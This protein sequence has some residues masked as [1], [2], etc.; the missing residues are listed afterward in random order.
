[1]KRGQI[2]M[3]ETIGI[4][5][6]FFFLIVI[7]MTAYMRFQ[8][9]SFNKEKLDLDSKRS[10]AVSQRALFLPELD[11]SFFLVQTP[12]CFDRM[13]LSQV[14]ELIGSSN[15]AKQFYF[16][17]FGNT[18]MTVQEVYPNQLAQEL[19]YDNPPEEIRGKKAVQSPVLLYNVTDKSYAFGILE[20]TVYE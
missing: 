17:L 20:V 2:Q 9:S 4:L 12:N 6:V 15:D 19:V 18:K 13:K 3:F 7:G 8:E 11:C 1:M 5:V 14:R 16:Q 10:L